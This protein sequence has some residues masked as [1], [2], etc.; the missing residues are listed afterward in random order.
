M[1]G[2][3]KNKIKEA[4]STAIERILKSRPLLVDI[5]PAIEVLPNMKKNSILHAGPPVEWKRMCGP[6]KGAVVATVI[7]EEL[8][9]NW[10]EA[11]KLIEQGNIE[12][13]SNHEHGAVGPMA[14]VISPS[15]PVLIVKNEKYGNTCFGRIVE[16]KVQFGVFDKYAINSE[17]KFWSETLAPALRKALLRS[18]GIDLK[19]IMARALH[20]GDELHNRSVAGTALFANMLIPY[21]IEVLDKQELVKVTKYFSRNE[22]FFLCMSMA[23]C[24]TMMEAAHDI[25]YSTLVT[26]MARNGV[27]FGIKVSGLGNQWFIGQSQ[28]IDGIYFPGYKR[29]DANPDIGDSAITE[30]AGIGAFA[31]ANSPAIMPLIG[32]SANDAIKY[33]ND[34]RKITIALNDTFSVPMLDFQGTA[35]GIDVRKVMNT[36]ILPVIDTA[37]A[38]KKAGIGMIGAGIVKPP[39]EA[40]KQAMYAFGQ[41]YK[42]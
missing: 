32:G 9:C 36:G 27:D 18:K 19:F 35:T 37:I 13:S 38:H 16:Q 17:L 14:G 5:K 23:A 20:M 42:F 34:M 29:D 11:V 31:L 39:L 1:N 30:T 21:L 10:D 7:F 25:E 26:V 33:T 12:F 4:N 2:K 22:I 15:L 8:A 40:F 28:M 24:K 41:K 3:L 6:M